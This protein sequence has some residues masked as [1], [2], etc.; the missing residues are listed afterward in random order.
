MKR[1]MT[2][3]VSGIL[4]ISLLTGCGQGGTNTQSTTQAPAQ[5]TTAS[6]EAPTERTDFGVVQGLTV[7]EKPNIDVEADYYAAIDE[8]TKELY[9]FVVRWDFVSWGET[10]ST[11]STKIASGDYDLIAVGPWGNFASYAQ[12]NA[13]YD[14]SQV[15]DEAPALIELFG[16]S[17]LDNIKINGKLC[18]V[19]CQS[20]TS[21]NCFTWR[22]DLQEEWGLEPVTDFDT[23]NAYVAKSRE[24]AGIPIC[25]DRRMANFF[26]KTL[27]PTVPDVT[28][29]QYN[30]FS[31]IVAD[32][33][34][35]F[36]PYLL[37]E[38]EEFVQAV[39]LAKKWYDEGIIDPDVLNKQ[40]QT[41]I[42]LFKEGTIDCL[43]INH[44]DVLRS[45]N[46]QPPA[47]TLNGGSQGD[48]NGDNPAGVEFGYFQYWPE[49][50]RL[51]APNLANSSGIAVSS[52]VSDDLAKELIKFI[53]KVHTEREFFD[54][55][56]YGTQGVS[57]ESFPSD[58][59]V[60]YGNIPEELRVY[61]KF[62][63]GFTNDLKARTDLVKYPQIDNMYKAI[64]DELN[65]NMAENPYNGFVFDQYHVEM[66]IEACNQVLAE[67][68]AVFCGMIDNPRQAVDEM[69]QAL[70]NAGMDKILEETIRQA[71]AFKEA[72]GQ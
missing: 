54:L 43:V 30:D 26:V 37:Y 39:E 17:T 11:Y 12:A 68:S 70:Y 63:L 1:K 10:S 34:T 36:E 33:E 24:A 14:L 41:Q 65:A 6:T 29:F 61:R 35:P 8:I 27:L 19:P 18:S 3:I 47:I 4:A 5:A 58:T 28:P 38:A 44:L 20:S 40:F 21:P 62:G 72:T 49:D 31:V 51:Y 60:N 56:Q 42:A 13:F 59:Q 25:Y 67:H 64:R 55:I 66:E 57:Y 23:M 71:Q 45:T 16:Q 52:R 7:G 15:I 32:Q 22:V 50:A 69:V 9:G 46:I 48:P 53:E 2:L